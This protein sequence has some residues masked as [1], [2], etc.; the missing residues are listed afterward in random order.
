MIVWGGERG[1]MNQVRA[2]VGVLA[3]VMLGL[4]IAASAAQSPPE[5]LFKVRTQ[6]S[7][8]D[9]LNV[10]GGADQGPIPLICVKAA[11]AW[12]SCMVSTRARSSVAS[13]TARAN[14]RQYPVF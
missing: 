14:W 11:C 13:R 9:Y 12:A 8:L 2:A 4:R 5:P 10:S 7:G 6:I 3:V 1:V